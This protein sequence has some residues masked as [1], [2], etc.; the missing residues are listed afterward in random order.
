M[1]AG[2]RGIYNQEDGTHGNFGSGGVELSVYN[3]PGTGIP[4]RTYCP[5]GPLLKPQTKERKVKRE[6]RRE[7]YEKEGEPRKSLK[8]GAP[9]RA[10]N[11]EKREGRKEKKVK[12]EA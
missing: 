10:R 11:K 2:N 9:Q 6:E 12:R 1:T 3:A 5:G 7:K 8:T 4:A